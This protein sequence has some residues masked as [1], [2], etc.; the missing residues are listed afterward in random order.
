MTNRWLARLLGATLLAVLLGATSCGGDQATPRAAPTAPTAGLAGGGAPSPAGE[1]P[2]TSSTVT[3]AQSSGTP[4]S[5]A[6]RPAA[7]GTPTSEIAAIEREIVQR[8]NDIRR[9][10]G[11]QPLEVDQELAR[12]AHDYSCR[13]AR[14]DFF[15]HIGP[16]GETVADRVREAG[17]EYR[18]VGEN[19][20]R[21]T[22][23]REPAEVAVQGW[24]DSPRH[25]ENILRPGFIETGVGVCREGARYYF[26]QVFLQ[27]R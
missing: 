16:D 22:N 1:R 7:A 19:L 10:Q 12:V 20:A 4:R 14:Q 3:G 17:K 8:I 2:E 18:L 26:T 27:P 25:R 23:A 24:M 6:G 21:N 11:L 5:G 15:S 9:E 13:M